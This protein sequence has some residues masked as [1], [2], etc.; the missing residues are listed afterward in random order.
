MAFP[1]Q[2]SAYFSAIEHPNYRFRQT[3]FF[4]L[5][6]FVKRKYSEAEVDRNEIRFSLNNVFGFMSFAITLK[7]EDAKLN[8][9]IDMMPVLLSIIFVLFA[10]LFM[11]QGSIM[12]S[13]GIGAIAFVV[14]YGFS[15]LIVNGMV[16]RILEA[17]V[18][19]DMKQFEKNIVKP[20]CI[21]CGKP[22]K[23]GQQICDSC[24]SKSRKAPNEETQVK[25]T[26][27]S[28]DKS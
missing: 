3:D 9:S 2:F 1:F 10:S 13:L 18:N 16:R 7:H 15:V 19:E 25:Y 8:Y 21:H 26:Y 17:F 11:A 20:V 27:V 5:R 14:L 23:I 6:D 4:H 28:D 12:L 22:M 24:Q